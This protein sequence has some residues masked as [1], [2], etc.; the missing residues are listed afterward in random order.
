MIDDRGMSDPEVISMDDLTI[1]GIAVSLAMDAFS[2]SIIAGVVIDKPDFRHY[3]RLAFHFGLFQFF[4]PIIGYAGG[5]MLEKVVGMYDHWIA[6]ILLSI[7][8]IKMIRESFSRDSGEERKNARDPSRGASLILLSIATSI[9]AIAIG[10]SF[11]MM[12][13][14][15]L[16][17]SVIIGVTCA[18]F[19][20]L[21]ILIGKKAGKYLGR[22]VERAGGIILISIGF[23]ILYEHLK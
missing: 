14:P 8:G 11:G 16:Y 1:L 22:W 18:L 20:V 13:A 10:F 15:I 9:D 4:M 3:F 19:S 17:P 5:V 12:N 2:V 21:G 23:K 6:L 7:V